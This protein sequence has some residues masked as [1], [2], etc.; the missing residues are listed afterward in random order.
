[1]N[2]PPRI[3]QPSP[4]GIDAPRARISLRVRACVAAYEALGQQRPLVFSIITVFALAA[5]YLAVFTPSYQT[6]D[7]V[8]LAMIVAGKGICLAPDEHLIF[9]NVVLGQ[10][11]RG[12]YTAFPS[13]PWYGCHLILVQV[14]S[15]IA[16]LYCAILH[17][18]SRRALLLYA[19]YFA[20]VGVYFLNNLQF[21]TTAFLAAQSGAM[22]CATALLLRVRTQKMSI[23]RPLVCGVLLLV[24]GALLRTDGYVLVL[25]SAITPAG[26]VLGS[27]AITGSKPNRALFRPLVGVLG[28]SLALVIGLVAYNDDYYQRDPQWQAFYDYN[29]LRLK[30]NDYQW[31]YYSPETA[32][33]FDAVGWSEN[34]HA[35]IANWFFDDAARYGDANLRQVVAGYPWR[36]GH[37]RLEYI[38]GAFR[39]L[40]RDKT[41]WIIALALP[42]FVFSVRGNRRAVAAVLASMLVSVLL[43]GVL[44]IATKPPPSRVYV[45][46]L[47]FPLTVALLA[48]G[49][50]AASAVATGFS[51]QRKETQTT[52][53][54]WLGTFHT[55]APGYRATVLVTTTLVIVAV[56][57]GLSRQYR[58]SVKAVAARN[59]L[60][61]YMQEISPSEDQLYVTWA[62][63][64]PFEAISPFDNLE[65]FAS[66][67]VLSLSWPQ[68]TPI[69]ED[70]KRAFAIDDLPRALH[71]RPDVRLIA[72]DALLPLYAT[73][74][75]EHYGR[76]VELVCD[77][78]RGHGDPV[79]V[80]QRDAGKGRI[81]TREPR[82]LPPVS[83]RVVR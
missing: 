60:A 37:W 67:R 31:T 41:S 15:Q 39:E 65:S 46:L 20:V 42:A 76:S 54:Y 58:R 45:P 71:E 2:F 38:A 57:M 49:H 30:F 26:I 78:T 16:V 69:A 64:F 36:H 6:N 82:T 11:L 62:S 56:C 79:M 27:C 34:D 12:L 83:W 9:S 35:M 28:A 44:A 32:A 53:T 48:A 61:Q 13:V 23:V 70:M 4:N 25:V 10:G 3:L 21:T 17:G 24:W 63:S 5:M 8:W 73:Y 18:Y 47:A 43:L 7:D 75:R 52:T 66:F 40:L 19:A 50:S 59:A 1:M 80:R 14:V 51:T 72:E 68:A 33:V 81:A 22:L 55:A 74:V 29:N 77:E